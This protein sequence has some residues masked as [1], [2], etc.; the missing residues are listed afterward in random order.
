MED[1]REILEGEFKREMAGILPVA[2]IL[3]PLVPSRDPRTGELE[4]WKL[5]GSIP[6]QTCL[7][8]VARLLSFQ[9]LNGKRLPQ[10]TAFTEGFAAAPGIHRRPSAL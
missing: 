7:N 6:A 5:S 4:L 1:D 3:W 10:L 9:F 2:W 8:E